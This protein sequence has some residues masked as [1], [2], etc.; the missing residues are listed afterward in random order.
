MSQLNPPLTPGDRIVLLHM[1]G[2]S[3]IKPGIAGTVIDIQKVPYGDKFDFH[4][5]MQWDNGSTLALE[6]DVDNWVLKSDFDEKKKP[7][8]G[9]SV[10]NEWEIYESLY[11]SKNFQ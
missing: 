8:L 10:K 5:L 2:P 4:Y 1:H 11:R 9:E 3:V 7:T 6:P